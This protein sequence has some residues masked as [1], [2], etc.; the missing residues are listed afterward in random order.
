VNSVAQHHD[1]LLLDLDGTVFRGHEPTPGAVESL[2]TVAAR[3]LYVTNNA[4]R[5]PGE[6]AEH[7]RSLGFAAAAED[8][9][10]SAQ[11]A[12]RL[13]A[14][15][16][17]AGAPVLVLGTEALAEE[18]RAVGLEPVRQFADRPV[19][20]VQGI[21]Q[22]TGW[23]GRRVVGR[24][25]CRPDTA[26][27]TRSAARQRRHDRR[28]AGGHRPGTRGGRKTPGDPDARCPEPRIIRTAPGGR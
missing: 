3:T 27:G 13:L 18:V 28:P 20:V 4:S 25:Q 21:S 19:A 1:C 2:R 11:S 8:V 12:A 10:T 6:V 14:T 24:H 9:V 15:T 5:A 22:Q 17:P 7:L 16:L 23:P 26:V